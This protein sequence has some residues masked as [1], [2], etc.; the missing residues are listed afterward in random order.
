M[1]Q[2]AAYGLLNGLLRLLLALDSVIEASQV[3]LNPV[4]DHLAIILARQREL[5][6]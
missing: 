6:S 4:I 2:T 3:T 5:C 1:R